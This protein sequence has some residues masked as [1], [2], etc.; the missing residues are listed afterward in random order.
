MAKKKR[1]KAARKP[2]KK[3][4]KRIPIA[5]IKGAKVTLRKRIGAVPAGRYRV[6]NVDGKKITMVPV[7][8]LSRFPV[9]VVKVG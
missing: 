1:K 6:T 4:A 5:P 8:H 7:K 3:A 9:Y 2:R